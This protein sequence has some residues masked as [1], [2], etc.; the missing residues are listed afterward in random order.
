MLHEIKG[1]RQERGG[2]G[3]RRW[4]ESE[5]LELVVWLDRAAAITGF[6][7]CYDV[8]QGEHAL[9]WR[10]E[11]GFAHNRVDSGDDTPLANRTPVLQPESPP[12]PWGKITQLF[13]QRSKT[14]EPALQQLIQDRLADRGA[15]DKRA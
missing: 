9:T 3:R 14:L 8:G 12:V 13:N 1:V 15:K 7:L 6:Q 2:A 4:F 10:E 11:S 5:G